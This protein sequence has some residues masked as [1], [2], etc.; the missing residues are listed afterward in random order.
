MPLRST[1]YRAYLQS[2]ID[3]KLR[4]MLHKTSGWGD[5][6]DFLLQRSLI[7]RYVDRE[8]AT[9]TLAIAHGDLDG[10]NIIIDNEGG[11]LGYA[12]I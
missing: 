7:S 4:K 11:L 12:P 3:G 9:G 10:Q 6:V 1:S 8:E 2:K 5:P